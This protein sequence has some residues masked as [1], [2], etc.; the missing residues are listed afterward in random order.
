MGNEGYKRR[1]ST[2]Q[3]ILQVARTGRAQNDATDRLGFAHRG[4]AMLMAT[5]GKPCVYVFVLFM[6]FRAFFC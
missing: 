4:E 1:H 6:L 5:S 2:N 3:G